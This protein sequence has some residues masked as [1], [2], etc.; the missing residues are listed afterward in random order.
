M[1]LS[2][3]KWFKATPAEESEA[4]L[5]QLVVRRLG[6]QDYEPIFKSM[7][8]LAENVRPDRDDEIW[9]LSHKPVYTQGQA[10]LGTARACRR[11][12]VSPLNTFPLKVMQQLLAGAD[13]APGTDAIAA[14][15][16]YYQCLAPLRGVVF[17]PL[18]E[19][20]IDLTEILL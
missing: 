11:D 5:P 18:E 15:G 6:L 12:Q 19:E 8:Y 13:I 4:P 1:Q 9:M 7:R 16:G 3:Y 20:A 2:T 17:L 14:A 10:G